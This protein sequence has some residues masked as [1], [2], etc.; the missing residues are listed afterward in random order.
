MKKLLIPLLLLIFVTGCSIDT[1]DNNTIN[2]KSIWNSI[3]SFTDNDT[4][5]EYLVYARSDKP[6]NITP[7][8]NADG[9]VMLN[10][11]CLNEKGE[12]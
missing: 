11:E 8:L 3:E 12:R 6:G 7:R 10:E 4:C 1:K 9:T 2:N 5:V